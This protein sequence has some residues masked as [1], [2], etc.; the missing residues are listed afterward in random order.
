VKSR[1]RSKL[2]CEIEEGHLSTSLCH[3]ANVSLRTGRK[4]TFDPKMETFPG[5]EEA[6]R[7]L[8]RQYREPYVVP[9]QV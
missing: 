2:H 6:N 8:R 4:L 3:L 5:D 1:D 9:D 7:F